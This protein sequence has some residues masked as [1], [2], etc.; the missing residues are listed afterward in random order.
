MFG[1]PTEIIAILEHYKYLVIFPIAVLEGPI[2]IVISGFLVFLGYLNAVTAFCLLVVADMLG[3]SMY[4]SIGKYGGRSVWV[5]KYGKIFGYNENSELFLEE[6]FRK[7]KGKTFLLAKISHGI[8]GAVQMASGVAKVDYLEFLFFSFI[9]TVP[10]TFILMLL[11]YYAGSSYAR[12]DKYFDSV[13]Y[14]VISIF[15]ITIIFYI[16]LNKYSQ[17]FFKKSE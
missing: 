13:A 2:I 7:H 17:K 9:G 5:K 11:G 1:T 15:I 14:V 3:D 4:Y 6:H 12:I 16:L 10:K 8:G